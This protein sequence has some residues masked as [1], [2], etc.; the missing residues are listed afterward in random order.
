[1]NYS[2]EH[3]G[4]AAQDTA[5]LKDWYVKTFG[6]EM[7]FTDGQLLAAFFV[8]LPGGVMLEIYQANKSLKDTTDNKLA[9][10]RHVAL[11]VDSIADS[12]TELESRGVKFTEAVAPAGGG[13]SVL[14][15][16]DCE[17]NLLHLVER[18]A[19]SLFH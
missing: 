9:G 18:P 13:G 19:G 16:E 4:L 12:K 15:F 17:G 8:K 11:Y 3:L 14:Y 5:A 1:M 7:V 10:W 6:G 2:V